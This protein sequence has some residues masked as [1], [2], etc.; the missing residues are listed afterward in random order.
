M[1]YGTDLPPSKTVFKWTIRAASSAKPVGQL[2]LPETPMEKLTMYYNQITNNG[3][4]AKEVSEGEENPL[5]DFGYVQSSVTAKEYR[6][7]VK[8]SERATLG[9]LGNPHMD[10]VTEATVGVVLAQEKKIESCLKNNA[11]GA[12]SVIAA[13]AWNS[14]GRGSLSSGTVDPWQG[15]IQGIREDLATAKN[16]IRE[17]TRGTAEPDTLV[18]PS[19]FMDNFDMAVTRSGDIS[20][21]GEYG[22][23]KIQNLDILPMAATYVDTKLNTSTVIC[24]SVAYVCKRGIDTG[25]TGVAEGLTSRPYIDEDRRMVTYQVW[26]TFTPVLFR[27]NNVA[28]IRGIKT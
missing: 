19:W 12:N 7:A 16:N 22:T 9:G 27:P 5:E 6:L 11:P 23:P 3:F 28:L 2:V 20:N 26:K 13:F 1:I 21:Y 4:L 24:D 10:A 8:V 25:G 14:V 17:A 18:V 15:F